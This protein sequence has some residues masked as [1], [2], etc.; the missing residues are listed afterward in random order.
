M[1]P[2]YRAL[3]IVLGFLSLLMALGGVLL[4]FSSKPVIERV[5]LH[6]PETEVS[7]LLLATLKEMGALA[8]MLAV[9]L[10][11]ASRD[12]KRNVAIIDGLAVGLCVSA[13]TPLLSF[14]TLDLG[15]LYPAY[16]IWA[17][18]L[19]R[20]ALAVILFYMRPR[21]RQWKPAGLF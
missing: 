5:F 13:V 20:L 16:A 10:F 4:I 19:V 3:R 6:P 11:L 7:T 9:M 8:L 2:S 12:P 18:S 15:N 21:E 14:Y 1:P 17:R